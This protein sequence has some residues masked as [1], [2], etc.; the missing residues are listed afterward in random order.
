MYGGIFPEIT[1]FSIDVVGG[2]KQGETE[3]ERSVAERGDPDGAHPGGY[4]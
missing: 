4:S 2:G 1:A 3:Y